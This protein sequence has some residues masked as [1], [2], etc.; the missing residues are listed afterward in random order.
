MN[1]VDLSPEEL[2]KIEDGKKTPAQPATNALTNANGNNVA[3]PLEEEQKEI[4]VKDDKPANKDLA[5]EDRKT[6]EEINTSGVSSVIDQ[7]GAES[8]VTTTPPT[9]ETQE[10][11]GLSTTLVPSEITSTAASS[12]RVKTMT[13]TSTLPFSG[14]SDLIVKQPFVWL[15]MLGAIFVLAQM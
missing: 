12:K 5:A 8:S 7:A 14:S 1:G 3:A 13:A 2:K 11:V 6:S 9:T 4:P 10:D 15:S